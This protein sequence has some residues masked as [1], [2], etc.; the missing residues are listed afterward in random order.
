MPLVQITML[1]GRTDA[2][3]RALLEAVTEAV[4]TSIETPVE[5]IRVWISEM[6]PIGY[7]AAGVLAADRPGAEP[8]AG[9]GHTPGAVAPGRPPEVLSQP[10]AT[11][12]DPS[13]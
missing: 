4:H 7:M 9:A 2:Q 6:E 13:R 3:K 11:D 10:A 8:P 12:P 1:R 5:S